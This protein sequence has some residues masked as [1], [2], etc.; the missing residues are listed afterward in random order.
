MTGHLCNPL[1]SLL[2]PFLVSLGEIN[3]PKEAARAEGGPYL[4]TNDYKVELFTVCDALDSA[5]IADLRREYARQVTLMRA[6]STDP[7]LPLTI[8]VVPGDSLVGYFLG[9]G[10]NVV[11]KAV[12]RSVTQKGKLPFSWNQLFDIYGRGRVV[13]DSA[14]TARIYR[15]DSLV[16]PTIAPGSPPTEVKFEITEADTIS[17]GVF[18]IMGVRVDQP[19]RR[20]LSS[21][22]YR[23]CPVTTE[24]KSGVYFVLLKGKTEILRKKILVVR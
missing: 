18:D 5:R 9:E 3:V 20:F 17:I 21:G 4:S 2:L 10:K 22:K 12:I 8:D 6:E 24:L 23:Y 19:N 7:T 11:Q 15:G 1:F 16:F 13:A 14:W